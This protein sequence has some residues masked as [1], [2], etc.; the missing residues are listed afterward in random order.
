VPVTTTTA[1]NRSKTTVR[2]T[3]VRPKAKVKTWKTQTWNHRVVR[4]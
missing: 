4:R 3:A 1:S 2:K